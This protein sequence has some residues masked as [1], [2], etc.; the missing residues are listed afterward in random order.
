MAKPI[1]TLCTAAALIPL[2]VLAAACSSSG[3]SS[4]S[5]SSPAA[6]AS[7]SA[8]GTAIT[9]TGST[10]MFP[11]FGAWQT[12]YNT[13]VP[14]V[15]ITTAGTG[16]GT[17]IA[18]AGT[19]TATIG[20]SDAYLSSSNMSQ[21]PGLMNIPLTVAALMVNYNVS[22]VKKPLNLNGTVLAQIY[23]GK[24]T[25]W[26]D[27]AIAKLNPGVTLPSEKIVTLHRADSSGSTFL[28]TSYLNAQDPGGWS[29]TNVGTTVSWPSKASALAETGSGGMVT[30]CGATKGCIAYI[31]ISYLS[32]TSTAG[33]GEASLANKA[34]KFTEPTPAAINAALASF[35]GSTPSSGSQSLINTSAPTGYPV[36]NYEYAVVKKTQP[37]ASTASNLKAFLTWTLTTGASSKYLS[38]VSF[39]P[40]PANVT[41]VAKNL[42]SSI[43]G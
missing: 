37:N 2:T 22:G 26:N 15:M 10:L 34:G 38:A 8:S 41:T 30:G 9:E 33:L 12:A 28:F 17:G 42:V 36:I 35:S 1:R 23:S 4:S 3:S 43:S 25:T 40:L 29:A 39:Q 19:G 18:D 27:P 11:L 32:K 24:I 13:A 5:S 20:A 14:S 6:A 31:G 16:S 7:S 21:Y